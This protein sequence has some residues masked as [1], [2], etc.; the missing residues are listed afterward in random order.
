M[1]DQETSKKKEKR[2]WDHMLAQKKK[3][4][5]EEGRGTDDILLV[6]ECHVTGTR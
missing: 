3:K 5:G 6:A 1:Y 4:D 2:R